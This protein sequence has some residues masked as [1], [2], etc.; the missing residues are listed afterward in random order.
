MAVRRG[1]GAA[2]E[3]A[4]CVVTSSLR[5]NRPRDG[6]AETYIDR[7]QTGGNGRI[8]SAGAIADGAH[9]LRQRPVNLKKF[10]RRE[11]SR[12]LKL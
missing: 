3:A 11:K 10:N 12:R 1:L 6:G 9:R 7:R 4:C 8:M 2:P 5:R